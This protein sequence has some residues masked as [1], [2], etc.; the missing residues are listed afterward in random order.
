[1]FLQVFLLGFV[2]YSI[3]SIGY[4]HYA[5][6]RTAGMFSKWNESNMKKEEIQ[7]KTYIVT[8]ATSGIGIS[9]VEQ[10]LINGANVIGTARSTKK[11]DDLKSHLENNGVSTNNLNI[12]PMD[13]MKLNTVD[14]F[15]KNIHENIQQLDGLILNAG[16]MLVPYKLS[17]DG[18]ESTF[19][20]NHLSH[21][22][23][24]KELLP[25]LKTSKTRVV[26]LSSLAHE[27]IKDYDGDLK[28]I[29]NKEK[30]NSIERY[31]LTKLQN[32]LMSNKL[33]REFGDSGAT[34]NAVH[35]GIIK[36]NLFAHLINEEYIGNTLNNILDY[37]MNVLLMDPLQGS[38]NTLY[39]AT[40]SDLNG[41]NGKYFR[42]VAIET[43]PTKVATNEEA[44]DRLW[45]NSIKIL[46]TC[47]NQDSSGSSSNSKIS[48]EE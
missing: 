16:I 10:L 20:S 27:A 11:A 32:I 36:T 38:L 41:V 46:E 31:G 3:F 45:E 21:F 15:I 34:S 42:P 7:G 4:L 30:Y 48:N 19:Q 29:N 5:G 22:K 39:V 44:A 9:T 33:A 24:V 26:V 1:M 35:P 8:G 43:N 37:I 14:T 17:E 6:G 12:I 23:I 13:L 47:T 18:N 40:S 2:G 25:L 28:D